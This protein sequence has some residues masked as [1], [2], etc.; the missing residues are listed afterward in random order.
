M[1]STAIIY[2]PWIIYTCIVG[3]ALVCGWCNREWGMA[4]G[5]PK[6]VTCVVMFFPT[7][8]A[9]KI[10]GLSN[11]HAAIAGL[12]MT[13]GDYVG[14]DDDGVRGTYLQKAIR[15]WRYL[16]VPIGF[17]LLTG[18]PWAMLSAAF[19]WQ[20]GLIAWAC[21]HLVQPPADPTAFAEP[22]DGTIRGFLNLLGL[23]LAVAAGV[24][25]PYL[26]WTLA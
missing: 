18:N 12:I 3:A 6:I 22:T 13:V 20:G 11:D 15:G 25:I 19:C 7:L 23:H 2:A 26:S 5:W 1:D 4:G 10:I 14:R 8:F 17:T 9:A 24:V 16:L 21:S